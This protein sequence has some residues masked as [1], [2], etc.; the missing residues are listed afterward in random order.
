L[1]L[2]EWKNNKAKGEGKKIENK[3]FS[4]REHSKI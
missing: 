3:L 4:K 2:R 1:E